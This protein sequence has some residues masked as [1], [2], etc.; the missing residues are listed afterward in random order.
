M[1]PTDVLPE[2]WKCWVISAFGMSAKVFALSRGRARFMVAKT[3][4][5]IGYVHTFGEAFKEIKCKRASE[6]D[7]AAQCC[8]REAMRD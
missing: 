5:E 8:G 3:L 6:Y 2:D 1:E 7:V 4:R